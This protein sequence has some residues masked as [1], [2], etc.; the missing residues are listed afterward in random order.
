MTK[1]NIPGVHSHMARGLDAFSHDLSTIYLR[2]E[3]TT[4]MRRLAKRKEKAWSEL[5]SCSRKLR[6]SSAVKVCKKEHKK[7]SEEDAEKG[8]A[9]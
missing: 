6:R 5:V 4:A 2:Y 8:Q 3:G 7:S 9:P 1:M